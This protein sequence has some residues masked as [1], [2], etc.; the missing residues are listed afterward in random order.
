M[1]VSNQVAP[2]LDADADGE[3]LVWDA[4]IDE[5]GGGPLVSVVFASEEAMLRWVEDARAKGREVLAWGE[6][7]LIMKWPPR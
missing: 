7:R 2:L 3:P 1:A 4:I 5:T 6:S